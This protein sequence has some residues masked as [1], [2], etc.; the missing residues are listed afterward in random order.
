M[1]DAISLRESSDDFW[2]VS[3]MQ[4]LSNGNITLKIFENRMSTP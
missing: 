2:V 4:K 1:A 3:E